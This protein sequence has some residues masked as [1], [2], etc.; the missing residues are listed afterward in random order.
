MSVPGVVATVPRV[1]AHV[2]GVRSPADIFNSVY[3]VFLALGTLVGAVVVLYT[4]YHA[5]KYRASKAEEDPYEGK[6]ERP[7]MG[8]KPA[9]GEG[10]R[11]VFVSFAISA[12]IVLSLI[13]WTYSLLLTV[14]DSSGVAQEVQAATDQAPLEVDV[15]GFQFGWQFT[16]PT[17]A[18]TSELVVPKD[19]VIRLNVTS[20]DV[21]HNFGIPEF[22]VK[23]DAIPGQTTRTWF[24]ANETGTHEA[25]CY[26]LCGTGHSYMNATVEVR[27]QDDFQQWYNETEAE[28]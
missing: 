23:A 25:N 17:G 16:Y 9:S 6:V 3:T 13:V 4:L 24:V 11:K 28:S 18:T 21:W 20:R 27:S 8:E 12:I 7:E 10:G 1:I 15:V 22:R 5:Y 26:D 2:G 19:R 14:E